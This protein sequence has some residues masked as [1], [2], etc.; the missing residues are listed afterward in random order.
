MSRE[1]VPVLFDTLCW[2]RGGEIERRGEG[3]VEKAFLERGRT[4]AKGAARGA[5]GNKKRNRFSACIRKGTRSQ[6]GYGKKT[7]TGPREKGK[8][9]RTHPVLI[10]EI[11]AGKAA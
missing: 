1:R 10:G 4:V 11:S 9:G 5:G 6:R 2:G 7:K 3:R 8:K